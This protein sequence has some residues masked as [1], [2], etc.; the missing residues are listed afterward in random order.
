[1][2]LPLAIGQI[3]RIPLRAWAARRTG[4]FGILS[5]VL[6]LLLIYLAAASAASAP[7]L[8]PT[9]ARNGLLFLY[10]AVSA[11]LVVVLAW[12]GA[13]LAG[14]GR[15]DVITAVFTG[16]QKTMD[17]GIPLITAYLSSRPDILAVAVLPIVFYHPVQLMVSGIARALFLRR[18]S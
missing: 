3:A 7:R 18:A 5:N 6:I 8:G 4:K 13:R 9:L 1:M 11:P 2:L 15:R 12:G 16:S 10:L 17:M 14:L